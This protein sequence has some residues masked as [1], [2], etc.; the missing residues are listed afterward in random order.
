MLIIVLAFFK[1]VKSHLSL[2]YVLLVHFILLSG[3]FT[4]LCLVLRFYFFLTTIL[5][6]KYYLVNIFWILFYFCF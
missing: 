5:S 3:A 6:I 1:R 2:L 4:D